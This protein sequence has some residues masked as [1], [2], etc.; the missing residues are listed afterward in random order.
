MRG[1]ALGKTYPR[2]QVFIKG[3]AGHLDMELVLDRKVH[4]VR[5]KPATLA[6]QQLLLPQG[7]SALSARTIVVV[8]LF[9]GEAIALV[10]RSAIHRYPNGK[11]QLEGAAIGNEGTIV[12]PDHSLGVLYQPDQQ[13]GCDCAQ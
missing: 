7:E 5:R 2:R 13:H 1:R 4:A 11:E 3:G 10:R 8:V 9:Y 12:C 6:D